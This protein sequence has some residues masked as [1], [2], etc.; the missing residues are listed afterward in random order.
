MDSSQHRRRVLQ[1][2]TGLTGRAD[3]AHRAA[4]GSRNLRQTR[5]AGLIAAIHRLDAS[6]DQASRD[7]IARYIRAEYERDIGDLPL[8]FVAECG[9]GPPYVDH[10]LNLGNVIVEH[11]AP[12]DTM[13]EPYARARTLVR[14]GAYVYVEIYVSGEIVPVLANGSAVI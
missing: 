4:T 9:L 2:G 10:I 12:A 13:P 7:D 5:S 6:V 14:S 3:H 8:G 1:S 11:Y